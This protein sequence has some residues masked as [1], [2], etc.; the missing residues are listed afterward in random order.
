MER[1]NNIISKKKSLQH[2]MYIGT[3][4]KKKNVISVVLDTSKSGQRR[5]KP[6][7]QA[8][9]I[10]RDTLWV[11]N[12]LCLFQTDPYLIHTHNMPYFIRLYFWVCVFCGEYLLCK[13]SIVIYVNII[14]ISDNFT[15]ILKYGGWGY[16]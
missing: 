8:F 9:M 13:H 7:R 1:S 2:I 6:A 15:D 16:I 3:S 14:L 5:K 12:P 4:M 10:I 11:Y